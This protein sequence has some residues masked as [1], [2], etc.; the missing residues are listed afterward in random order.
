LKTFTIKW[1]GDGNGYVVD[2]AAAN[3]KADQAKAPMG[4]LDLGVLAVVARVF[5]HG[6]AKY[7][8]DNHLKPSTASVRRY[9]GACLRHLEAR[10][11]GEMIDPDSGLPHLG[12]AIAS[13]MIALRHDSLGE[14]DG[15][16]K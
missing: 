8:E 10:Q 7:A 3:V 2:Q 11:R 14:L 6:N 13:L 9:V 16:W 5:G 4:D 15:F 1:N 12:H